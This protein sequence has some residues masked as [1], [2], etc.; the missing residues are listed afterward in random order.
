MNTKTPLEISAFVN[1]RL[2]LQQMI[3]EARFDWVNSGIT[4]KHFPIIGSSTKKYTFKIFE[5]KRD[6][7]SY[8]AVELMRNDGF[9]AARHEAGLAFAREFPN[10]QMKFPIALLGSPSKWFGSR[11]IVCL[12]GDGAKRDLNLCYW[13]HAWRGRWGFLGAQEISGA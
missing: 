4:A 6:I 12:G 9:P 13:L 1:F 5:P 8:D 11:H 2:T 10:E 7:S 3:D